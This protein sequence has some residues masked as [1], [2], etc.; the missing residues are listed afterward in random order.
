MTGEDIQKKITDT[1]FF[2][3]KIL[4]F[5]KAAE[6]GA[7]FELETKENALDFLCRYAVLQMT[8]EKGYR[9]NEYKLLK[10][11]TSVMSKLNRTNQVSCSY[12]LEKPQKEFI[13]VLMGN[14]CF[15]F[16]R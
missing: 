4:A 6:S 12:F 7:P 5:E 3:S 9:Y 11:Y 15:K 13:L 8:N 14:L 16:Y 1:N 10:T 2:V